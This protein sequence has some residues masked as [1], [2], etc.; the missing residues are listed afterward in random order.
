VIDKMLAAG[1]SPD[2][3]INVLFLRCRSR[4]PLES[5]LIA[6][7]ADLATAADQKVWL[8]DLFWSLLNSPEFV[9]NH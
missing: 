9:F 8:E 1:K 2:D 6:L 3:V 7:K 4:L 5:E